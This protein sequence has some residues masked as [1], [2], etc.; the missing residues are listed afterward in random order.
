MTNRT[1]PL[2]QLRHVRVSDCMHH[3]ILSCAADAPLAEVAGIMAEHR[4][5]AVVVNDP[6]TGRP[7]GVVSDLDVTSAVASGEEPRALEMAATEALAI[8]SG[9]TLPQAAQM[10]SEHA[11]SHL[12]VLDSASGHPVGILSALDL[13]GVYAG[14]A[15]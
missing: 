8:S 4:V 9:E 7:F 13:A 11:V 5:H 15:R 6:E 12:V 14:T 10:M 3:G 2:P 1:H